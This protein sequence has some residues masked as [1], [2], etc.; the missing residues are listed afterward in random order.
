MVKHFAQILLLFF[1]LLPLTVQ[2][3]EVGDTI[4]TFAGIDMNG[5]PVDLA[6]VIGKQPVM[7][8]FWASW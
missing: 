8:V 2:A 7:L 1:L 3:I 4:P 5:K 6:N